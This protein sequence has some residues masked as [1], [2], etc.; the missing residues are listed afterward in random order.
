MALRGAG[1]GKGLGGRLPREE[2]LHDGEGAQSQVQA[3]KEGKG[4]VFKTGGKEKVEYRFGKSPREGSDRCG[5]ECHLGLTP[6]PT[7]C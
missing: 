3:Q 4:N 6:L 1:A 5:Q 7:L 2:A